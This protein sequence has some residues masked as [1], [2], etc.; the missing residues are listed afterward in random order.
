VET[1]LIVEDSWQLLELLRSI[2]LS[3]GLHVLVAPE[4]TA[5]AALIRARPVDVIVTDFFGG[6]RPEDCRRSVADILAVAGSRP[7]L[8]VTGRHFEPGTSPRLFGV[9]D[10]VAK[11]FEVEDLVERVLRLLDIAEVRR[12]QSGESK[13]ANL[14]PRPPDLDEAN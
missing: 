1:V 10:V 2:L 6:L 8:G 3:E 11:P 7:I 14:E 12:R 13:P 9:D 5:A 4:P